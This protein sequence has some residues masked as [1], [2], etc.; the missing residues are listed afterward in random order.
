[1]SLSMVLLYVVSVGASGLALLTED[2]FTLGPGV[3]YLKT[4][5]AVIR[6][7]FTTRIIGT[8][9]SA[10]LGLRLPLGVLGSAS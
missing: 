8:P 7:K 5:R 3:F 1:M 10:V 6:D 2:L 9:S 4:P